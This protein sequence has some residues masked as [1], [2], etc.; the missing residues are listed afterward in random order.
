VIPK[1]TVYAFCEKVAGRT[2][3]VLRK[4]SARDMRRARSAAKRKHAGCAGDRFCVFLSPGSEVGD[5]IS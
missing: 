4:G 2:Y 1:S 3:R 5:C